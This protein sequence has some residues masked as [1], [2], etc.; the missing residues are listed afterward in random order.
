MA[1]KPTKADLEAENA[2]LNEALDAVTDALEDDELSATRKVSAALD[3]LDKLD[4]DD[5][6]GDGDQD[7]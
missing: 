7:E 1:N 6:D 5:Q 3:E 4:D 2:S